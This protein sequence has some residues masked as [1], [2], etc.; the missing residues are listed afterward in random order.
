MRST[1]AS[2]DTANDDAQL[3]CC[4]YYENVLLEYDE[5]ELKAVSYY[6]IHL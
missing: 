5:D 1:F 2:T 4:E 3:S 6:N